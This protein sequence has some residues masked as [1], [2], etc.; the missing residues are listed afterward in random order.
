MGVRSLA[1]LGA[2][3][4]IAAGLLV[5]AGAPSQ[6]AWPRPDRT[7]P[8]APTNFRAT[9]ATLTSVSLA[10]GPSTDNVGVVSYSVWY[11]GGIGVQ[12]VQPP[13]TTA[14]FTGLQP[15]TTYAFHIAAYDARFNASATRSVTVT[16]AADTGAPTSPSGLS[17][18][19]VDRGKVLLQWTNGVD[20]SGPV[21]H[22]VLVDG[23]VTPN[24][25]STNPPGTPTVPAEGAWIRH[26]EPGTTYTFTVRA[27][28]GSG[29]VSA[30]SN[31]VTAT[32]L[33]DG[34]VQAPTAPVLTR[35]SSLGTSACPEEVDVR[36]TG[37]TDDVVAPTAIEYEIWINGVINDVFVG[38]TRAIIYTEVNGTND[39]SIVAVD[40]AGNASAR[41]NVISEFTRIGGTCPA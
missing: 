22:Q 28:D 38:T 19:G 8:T 30:P 12:S 27:V 33:P 4:A 34:D 23:V 15:G 31:A 16:T 25:W 35:V 40:P 20:S 17:V 13:Q 32:T 5:A 6:A 9:A 29:N 36:W 21:T 39:T 2:G 24:A 3:I 18:Q 1:R 11:D 26:L 10:W 7:P 41:S 14:T 37:S